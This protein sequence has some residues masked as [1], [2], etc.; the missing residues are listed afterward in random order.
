VNND[1][2]EQQTREQL[3]RLGREYMAAGQFIGRTGYAALRMKHGDESY[4]DVAIDNWMYASP[5]YT[6]RM[7]RAMG[8]AGSDVPTIFKGLQLE[9]GFAHQY[10]DVHF[11]VQSAERGRFWL[12][13]CGPLLE[14][15]PRGERAV[16]TMCHDIEDPT[17]DATAVAT[18]PRARVRPV[19]RP[20]RVPED[21][22]PHC[23][24]NVF[25][26]R[27]ADPLTERAGT[28]RMRETRLANLDIVRPQ[29]REPG[30]MDFYDGPVFEVLQ[31]E[32]LSHAA[33]VVVCKE[34]AVQIHLLVN[35]LM[36]S[37]EERYG[38]ESA[39][40]VAAFQMTGSTWV[41]SERLCHWLG[42]EKQGIDRVVD[43]L[44]V[45]P[46]FQPAEYISLEVEKTGEASARL[47]FSPCPAEH[48]RAGY[49]W[50]GLLRKG[51]VQG[52][53]ALLKGIDP[54]AT[55]RPVAGDGLAW[56]IAID[57]SA[58]VGEEPLAVQIAKGTVLYKTQFENHI[59]LLE[60]V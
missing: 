44:A 46:A 45:H 59:P 3:A 6:R 17:F 53:E 36:L 23:E 27:D 48:E 29:S 24:W 28:R 43:I 35:S 15:E 58:S 54:R 49:G 47:H 18:N 32:R 31:L 57:A 14:T 60:L 16:R 55:L 7:Q 42:S 39:D 51:D 11:E 21:R 33:L 34:L 19:H 9:V 12:A 2:F 40:A 25:I 4:R 38:R 10:F 22:T 30:G 8:F 5:V 20:P 1:C 37:I 50:F 41:V 56:D 26:D 13:S 52:L